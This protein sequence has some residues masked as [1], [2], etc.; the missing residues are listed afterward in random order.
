MKS[1]ENVMEQVNFNDF[2]AG[3]FV[4]TIATAASIGGLVFLM[5]H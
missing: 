5:A 4:L 1:R 3:L 2:I